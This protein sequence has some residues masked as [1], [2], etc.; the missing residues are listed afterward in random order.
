MEAALF[1]IN[2]LLSMLNT[3]VEAESR[4]Q[5]MIITSRQSQYSRRSVWQHIRDE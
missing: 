4:L 1:E 5:V 2:G 3:R